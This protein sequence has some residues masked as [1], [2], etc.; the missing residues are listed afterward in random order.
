MLFNIFSLLLFELSFS[1]VGLD[2]KSQIE[3]IYQVSGK[4]GNKISHVIL[5]SGSWLVYANILICHTYGFQNHKNSKQHYKP[6]LYTKFQV[7]QTISIFFRKFACNSFKNWFRCFLRESRV[8]RHGI[9]KPLFQ[10]ARFKFI[11]HMKWIFLYV[12]FEK[13]IFEIDKLRKFW[14]ELYFLVYVTIWCFCFSQ[15]IKKFFRE[16]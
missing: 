7:N 8:R 12:L 13:N 6:S 16:I 10:V 1:D 14:H 11:S 2:W 9:S 15:H 3:F 4:F 5:G